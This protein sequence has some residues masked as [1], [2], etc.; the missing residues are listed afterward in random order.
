M[1]LVACSSRPAPRTRADKTCGSCVQA[2]ARGGLQFHVAT[3]GDDRNP[4]TDAAPWRTIQKAM[5][6]ATP[7]ATVHIAAGRYVERLE[8]NVSGAMDAYITFQP[9]GFAIPAGG[10]G[11]YTGVACGGDKVIVDLA[12]FG[13]PSTDGVPY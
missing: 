5:D 9:R 11:G 12:P 10:C 7:G 4:G 6:A 3:T 13:N 8:V 1:P 2:R